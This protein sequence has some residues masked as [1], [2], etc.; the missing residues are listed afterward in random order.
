MG[1]PARDLWCTFHV[2][3]ALRNFMKREHCPS[4]ILHQIDWLID[5]YFIYLFFLTTLRNMLTLGTY[6]SDRSFHSSLF[7][8]I[9]HLPSGPRP[10]VHPAPHHFHHVRVSH[11]INCELCWG[12]GAVHP[13][14]DT[15]RVYTA[16][17][18]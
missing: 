6:C 12:R 16:T 17:G 5:F 3:K 7:V 8:L 9:S 14:H 1:N 4:K 10:A 2:L 15:P 11:S 18:T 13:H